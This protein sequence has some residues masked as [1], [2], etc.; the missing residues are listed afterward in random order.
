MANLKLKKTDLKGPVSVGSGWLVT[1]G[2][3]TLVGDDKRLL[4]L[5]A[6]NAGFAGL[7]SVDINTKT[8]DALGAIHRTPG[9]GAGYIRSNL[10][11][12][13]EDG[14][15]TRVYRNVS[16]NGAEFICLKESVL[17][18]LGSPAN[19]D[20]VPGK[21]FTYTCAAGLIASTTDEP[22]SWMDEAVKETT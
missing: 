8:L 10:L 7:D 11:I 20:R 12:E 17:L 16:A 21:S 15:L 22:P 19:V 3:A 9:I 13:G 4:N 5:T 1:R 2:W 6:L 14:S 18:I